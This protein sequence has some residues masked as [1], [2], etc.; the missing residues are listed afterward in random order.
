MISGT[1][2]GHTLLILA[3][4]TG[5]LAEAGEFREF[6]ACHKPKRGN[7][8]P[9]PQSKV[10]IPCQMLDNEAL[11]AI[12]PSSLSSLRSAGILSAPDTSHCSLSFPGQYLEGTSILL[13]QFFLSS[14][15]VDYPHI[16]H[17]SVKYLR[18]D[19]SFSVFLV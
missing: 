16:H 6:R 14:P 9:K 10:P 13:T 8:K 15:S 4:G 7:N 3:P 19:A 11:P 1:T 2:W 12:A 18:Q 17:V 5:A